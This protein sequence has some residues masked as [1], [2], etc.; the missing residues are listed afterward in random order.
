MNLY[1]FFLV[2]PVGVRCN[3]QF[4]ALLTL[5][6]LDLLKENQIQECYFTRFL[7]LLLVN[8]TST[9]T[10]SEVKVLNVY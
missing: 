4:S 1:C 3:N 2:V 10:V 8:T 7:S 9:A 5:Q 6:L